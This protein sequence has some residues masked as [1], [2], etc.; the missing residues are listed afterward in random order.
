MKLKGLKIAFLG[1]SITNGVGASK[2]NNVYHQVL[3]EKA[4][5]GVL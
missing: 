4:E 3:K 5:L 2:Y 1:D